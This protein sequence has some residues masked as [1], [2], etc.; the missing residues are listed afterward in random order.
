MDFLSEYLSRHSIDL[1]DPGRNNYECTISPSF[2]LSPFAPNMQLINSDAIDSIPALIDPENCGDLKNE[3]KKIFYN[4]NIDFLANSTF[5][6][7][8]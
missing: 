4:H 1:P 6:S 8:V 3:M 5:L 2:H 7:N